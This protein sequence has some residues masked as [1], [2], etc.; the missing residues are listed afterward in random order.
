MGS[1]PKFMFWFKIKLISMFRDVL[2]FMS[3]SANNH[4]MLIRFVIRSMSEFVTQLFKL[5]RAV[6][7]SVW[8][9]KE[10]IRIIMTSCGQISV[11]SWTAQAS[12]GWSWLHVLL[13]SWTTQSYQTYVHV[14]VYKYNLLSLIRC[15]H[16]F[17]YV[18]EI[19]VIRLIRTFAWFHARFWNC[20]DQI[21]Q[22][23]EKFWNLVD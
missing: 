12:Q 19:E 10:L 2:G 14:W 20:A 22:D 5:I 6:C 8:V 1:T 15:M 13:W 23:T 17:I 21:D 16:S 9:V 11:P 7:E 4:L 3:D 18:F